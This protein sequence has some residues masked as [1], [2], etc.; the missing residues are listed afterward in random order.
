MQ[1]VRARR[2]LV[3]KGQTNSLVPLAL[4]SNFRSDGV[5]ASVNR[6]QGSYYLQLRTKERRQLL[7][8][9]LASC[10]EMLNTNYLQWS[11]DFDGDNQADFLVSFDNTNHLYLSSYAR[12]E[13][14]VGIAGVYNTAPY[15]D[16]C[17][18]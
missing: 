4:T 12:E 11:G 16:G 17:H 5:N 18:Y 6:Y 10:P 15:E 7:P 9:Y 2:L 13:Q 3:A 1:A 8:A 14:I